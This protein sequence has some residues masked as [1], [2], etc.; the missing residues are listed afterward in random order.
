M[1]IQEKRREYIDLLRDN[2]CEVVFTKADGSER[3]MFATIKEKYLPRA[4]GEDGETTEKKE[5]K[6]NENLI[7][8][9][10]YEN[11]SWR[12]FKIDSVKSF[13]VAED[14]NM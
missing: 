1:D 5:R 6:I 10:D 3:V 2:I 11:K 4:S 14:I 8:C 13:I 7:I 12:S 9:F